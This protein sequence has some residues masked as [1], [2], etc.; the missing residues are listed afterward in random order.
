ML[1]YVIYADV[2]LQELWAG[3]VTFNNSSC[4]VYFTM[5]TRLCCLYTTVVSSSKN[6]VS[7]FSPT[8]VKQLLSSRIEDL[9]DVKVAENDALPQYICEK[10]KRRVET[11]ER[12][13]KNFAIKDFY[14][15]AYE[16]STRFDHHSILYRI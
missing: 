4:F 12:A 14:L 5:A 16:L 9:L 3:A 8:A 13:I 2:T 10:F 1:I 15:A 6:A 7:L 11:L